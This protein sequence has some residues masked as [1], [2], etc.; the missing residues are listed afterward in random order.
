V[1]FLYA[2]LQKNRSSQKWRRYDALMNPEL[3]EEAAEEGAA[4]DEA[5]AENDQIGRSSRKKARY[6]GEEDDQVVI[7]IDQHNISVS[8]DMSLPPPVL[9]PE[10]PLAHDRVS[11]IREFYYLW[12]VL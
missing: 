6:E 1:V 8:S 9:I 7:R 11:F 10:A 4:E 12:I 5:A 3:E 2:V